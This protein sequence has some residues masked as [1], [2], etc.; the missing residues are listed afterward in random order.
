VEGVAVKVRELS[1]LAGA[2]APLILAGSSSA[3]FYGLEV[4]WKPNAFT[5]STWNIY[6]LFDQPP[7]PGIA[8]DRMQAVAGTPSQPLLFEVWQDWPPTNPATFYQHQFGTDTAPSTTLI[9]VFP[10]LAFDTFVTIGMKATTP[11]LPDELVLSPTWPG[12]G[13][14]S[15]NLTNDSWAVTPDDP[16]G[17]P[18]NPDYVQGNGKILIG[19]FSTDGWFLRFK[20]LIQWRGDLDHN[21]VLDPEVYEAYVSYAPPT[22]GTLWL[23]GAAGFVARRRC[24]G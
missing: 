11:S 5:N 1:V 19:Q 16:Q 10:S 7:E 15:L 2:G 4:I 21:G 20:M 17:D 13:P 8:G 3:D 12:F 18:F 9:G 22:P 24:R 23:L 14:S 6:A